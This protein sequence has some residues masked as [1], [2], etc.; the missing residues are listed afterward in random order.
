MRHTVNVQSKGRSIFSMLFCAFLCAA[1]FTAC[2]P[3]QT[4]KTGSLH[5]SFASSER[6]QSRNINP[7]GTSPLAIATYSV[8]GEGPQGKVLATVVTD[9]PDL[10]INGL[11]VGNWTFHVTAYNSAGKPLVTGSVD[12]YVTASSNSVDMI[13]DEA[14][15]TGTMQISYT[16][17]TDQTSSGATISI[18]MENPAGTVSQ[19]SPTAMNEAAGTATFNL[20]LA[21]GFHTLRTTL[22]SGTDIL[23]GKAE[24]IRI[25]DGTVTSGT[26]AL[27]IGGEVD[28]FTLTIINNTVAPIQGSIACVP[29]SPVKGGTATL[30]YTPTLPAGI[31]ATDLSAQWYFEGQPI[32]GATTFTL[33]IATV[34]AGTHRYDI[35][36][37]HPLQGSIGSTG[38][39]IAVPSTAIVV[40]P[41]IL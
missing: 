28:A 34:L 29:V 9:H 30:T 39:L 8:S 27:D 14:V 38:A 37:R 10:N 20:S 3:Q 4:D 35:V 2:D 15:G 16:W 32:V 13:M 21:A 23:S 22:L 17:N 1:M 33:P 31:L 18:S 12:T 6:Y 7:T 36:I 25:I 24:T 11:L 40:T 41:I 19:H 26:I 5:L